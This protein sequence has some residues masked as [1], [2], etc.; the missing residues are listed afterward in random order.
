MLIINVDN[1]TVQFEGVFVEL[2]SKEFQLLALLTQSGNLQTKV[3]V[4]SSDELH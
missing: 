4:Y 1:R 3:H 2:T